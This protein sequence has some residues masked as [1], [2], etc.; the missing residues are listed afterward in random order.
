MVMV[1]RKGSPCL[2]V[3]SSSLAA[4]FFIFLR[5]VYCA[6]PRLTERLEE[7]I[8]LIKG[9]ASRLNGLKN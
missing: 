4:L 3:S 6:A 8:R 7:A 2:S 1:S 9:A 5:A